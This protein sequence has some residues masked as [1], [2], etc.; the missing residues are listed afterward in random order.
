MYKLFVQWCTLAYSRYAVQG[1]SQFLMTIFL[2]TGVEQ[3]IVSRLF[4]KKACWTWLD[5]LISHIV[6]TF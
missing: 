5:T 2:K 3:K 6:H 1:T 4:L